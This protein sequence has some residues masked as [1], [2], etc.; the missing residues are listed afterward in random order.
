MRKILATADA[1]SLDDPIQQGMRQ[2]YLVRLSTIVRIVLQPL[3]AGNS[4]TKSR[5]HEWNRAGGTGKAPG[6]A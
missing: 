5:P 2:I 4:V 3:M 1:E 6:G